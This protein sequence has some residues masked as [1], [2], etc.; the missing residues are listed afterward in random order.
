ML[1]VLV[2]GSAAGGGFPQWNGN[3]EAARRARAG[4][5]R[6]PS[7]TQSSL[8]VSADGRRWVLLNASPDLRQQIAERRQL[9]PGP[10]DAK[11]SSPIAA[12]VLTNADVD[13]VAGLLTLRE[14]HRFAI[15]AHRRVLDVLAQ[16]PI[17]NVLPED[18]VPRASVPL[19][20]RTP[21]RD[22]SGDSLGFWIEAFAVPGKA[23]LWC[24]NGALP[25][26]GTQQGDTVGLALG[27]GD[28]A[29]ALVYVPGCAA[30]SE[31]VA[32]RLNGAPLVLFDGTLWRDDEMILQNVGT[33]TGCRMGH[34]SCAGEDGTMAAFERL[35]VKRKF[36]VH[37][38]NTN[39]LLDPDSPE[40]LEAESR[41]WEVA[42]DGMEIRA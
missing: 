26:W 39:P 23:P 32:D 16:N 34:M 40:R 21:I 30:M 38:N 9:Q 4:D 24:E 33:K 20:E 22:P 8:A 17:F 31:A 35:N 2:L 29:P 19:D 7:R 15:Y 1:H 28:G 27:S 36:F 6:C 3:D 13:H 18:R 10:G 25:S 5:P 42:W 11:R 12:V 14:N 37:I 41:G